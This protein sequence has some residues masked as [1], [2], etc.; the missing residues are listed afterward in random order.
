MILGILCLR[1]FVSMFRCVCSQVYVSTGGQR[2][3]EGIFSAPLSHFWG[4]VSHWFSEAIR[5]RDPLLSFSLALGLQMI[6]AKPAFYISAC[7]GCS[8]PIWKQDNKLNVSHGCI[9]WSKL[10]SFESMCL[11]GRFINKCRISIFFWK[12]YYV[13]R[14]T[15]TVQKRR[16]VRSWDCIV[17]RIL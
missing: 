6:S 3:M 1:I 5:S 10:F 17:A 15:E 7:K 9:L 11:I 16:D 12:V 13:W 8:L 4:R 14:D 2:S